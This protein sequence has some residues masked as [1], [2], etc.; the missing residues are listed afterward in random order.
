MTNQ[1]NRAER[2][3]TAAKTARRQRRDRERVA[4]WIAA[5]LVGLPLLFAAAWL[6]TGVSLALRQQ[7]DLLAARDVLHQRVLA[8]SCERDR[9]TSR[10]YVEARAKQ[11]GLGPPKLAQ[12]RWIPVRRSGH[13]GRGR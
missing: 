2:A 12:V 11:L 6:R 7:D 8:L 1:I 10:P 4:G 9:L 13:G 3:G 5:V